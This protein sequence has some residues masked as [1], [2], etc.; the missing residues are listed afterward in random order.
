MNYNLKHFLSLFFIVI[1][2]HIN[3]QSYTINGKVFDLETKE[4][5]PF[6]PV[7][8]QGTTIGATTDFDGNY[9]ITTSKLSDTIICSYVSYKKLARFIKRG[10]TQTVNFPLVSDAYNLSEVVIKPGEN[11]AH[12]IIKNVIANLLHN[13][14]C[15]CKA[16]FNS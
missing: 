10:Q 2:I 1:S 16:K 4:P 7:I 13:C 14:Y 8:L 12:R 15:S 6:V 9:A 5:L 3:A 11:P